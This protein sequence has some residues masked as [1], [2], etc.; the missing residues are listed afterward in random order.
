MA[1]IGFLILILTLSLLAQQMTPQQA[2][3]NR[4]RQR[5][6]LAQRYQR[7]NDHAQAILILRTLYERSPGNP[8]YYR[9]LLDSYLQLSMLEEAAALVALQKGQDPDNPQYEIDRGTLLIKSDDREGALRVWEG[10]LQQYGDQVRFYTQVAGAMRYNRLYEEAEKTYLEAYQRHP[11]QHYLLKTLGDFQAQRLKFRKALETYLAFLEKEPGGLEGISRQVLSF[12]VEG[13]AVDTLSTMLEKAADRRNSSR[14]IR[15]LSA[16]YLQKHGRYSEALDLYRKLETTESNGRLLV[17]FGRRV[18]N[19][20]LPNLALKAYQEVL[21]NYPQSPHLMQA[22]LG[23][24]Q[25][26]LDLAHRKQDQAEARGAIEVIEQVEKSYPNHPRTGD[27]IVLKGD[28]YRDFFFDLDRAVD[29]YR[30]A[31]DKFR[32]GD[33][34]LP[35]IYQRIASSYL[36]QGESDKTLEALSHIREPVSGALL[37]QARTAYF[38]G[39]FETAGVLADS[40]MRIE[41]FSGDYA[42]D[43]LE[44]QTV[45]GFAGQGEEA[46]RNYARASWLLLQQKKNEALG[47]LDKAISANPPVPLKIRMLFEAAELAAQTREFENAMR[48]CQQVFDDPA[49]ADYAD[50]ALFTMATIVERQG[51]KPDQ[52]F[53]LYDRLLVEFPGSSY[54]NDARSRLKSLREKHPG[55]VP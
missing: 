43:A 16:R 54:E 3:Q 8:Q 27:L 49:L 46:L 20:S 39:D 47:M 29:I 15:L 6:R 10:V 19:D 21:D 38:T 45:L 33:E 53:Q 24:A 31:L 41:G 48:Y 44:L 7:N 50:Q 51:E 4:D 14:E 18:Q 2:Q 5:L 11:S 28:I 42:N 23:L 12:R 25:S 36:I 34:H 32:P 22:Y 55:L 52:A 9:E 1:K 37:L 13:L 26:H 40:L 30:G 35:E 17:D